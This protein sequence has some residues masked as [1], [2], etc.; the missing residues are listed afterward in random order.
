MLLIVEN[1]VA[2][3]GS[4]LL[5]LQAALHTSGVALGCRHFV[6]AR[7]GCRTTDGTLAV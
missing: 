6:G 4:Q 7:P 5:A 2:D 3:R 1:Y